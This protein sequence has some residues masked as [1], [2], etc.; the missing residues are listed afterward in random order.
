MNTLKFAFSSD[1]D[2]PSR[3]FQFISSLMGGL[4]MLFSKLQGNSNFKAAV[5]LKANRN[6][7]KHESANQHGIL[8]IACYEKMHI[9]RPLCVLDRK[10]LLT[11]L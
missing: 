7:S 5:H 11:G 3:C 6:K 8:K 4:D 1:E 10:L 9:T 2:I